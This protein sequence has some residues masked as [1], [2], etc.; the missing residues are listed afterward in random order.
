MTVFFRML[1]IVY[2]IIKNL[3]KIR[4]VQR[5]FFNSYDELSRGR[6]VIMCTVA[7]RV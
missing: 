2:N 5:Y 3:I 7:H 6:P 1:S 4:V